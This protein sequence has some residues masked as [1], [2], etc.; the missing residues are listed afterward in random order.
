LNDSVAL[1][2]LGL[3]TLDYVAVAVY[4]LLTF[5]IAVWFSRRQTN[6][7][8]F[9]V[10]GR[11]MP[12]LAVGLSILATLF[13]TISYLG[14]P[15]EMIK[16]GI[17]M[18][19]GYL[20]VPV[21]VLVVGW[22]WIPFFM[23]LR[24]TSAYEYL[25]RRFSRPV[26]LIGA[27]LFILLRL[28]WMSMVIFVAS[29][30]LNEI[31][32]VEVDWLPGPDLYWWIGGIGVVA[33]I[34][35]AIGGIQAVVWVDVLQCFLLMSGVLMAIFYVV[36]TDGTGPA[37]WWR[38]TSENMKS[39]TE[40]PWI[41]FDPTVR[42]TIVTAMIANFFWNIC[43]HGSDQVVLQR[44]FSTPSLKAARR[45]YFANVTVDLT[46]ATLLSLAGLAL[47]AFYVRHGALLPDGKTAA[48]MADKLFPYFLG[49]QLPVG[50]GGLIVSAFLCDAIQTL[51]S[52][53]NA[54]TAVVTRDLL[55]HHDANRTEHDEL[56]SVRVIAFFAALIV[57]ANAFLIARLQASQA[58]T[59]VDMMSKFFN[60]FA[61]PL[62]ALFFIGMFLPRCT[63]RSAIPAAVAG[64]TASVLWSWWEVLFGTR[65]VPTINLSVAG[66]C[67]T[68]FVIAAAL[69]YLIERPGPHAGSEYTWR[70]VISRPSEF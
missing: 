32:G 33:A 63:T 23:R 58:L 31:K 70:A 10:G 45:S 9:F 51:E 38:I 61:G 47:L 41:S 50:C 46:M 68:T 66:P 59:I 5:G 21:T 27:T 17:G 57:T 15:G 19:Y 60:M 42:M 22:V 55:R 18:F 69:G 1:P 28:G 40:T 16:H 24:L 14:V 44:Y 13:S 12:W 54:I 49:H 4:L 65:Y 6:V 43:T 3:Q 35:A 26:Q 29:M 7:E 64:M 53:V 36:M 37:D 56:R 11:R 62:A 25:N 8:D 34:Y 30:A 48:G 67:V 2:H 20:A 39:H 52:G